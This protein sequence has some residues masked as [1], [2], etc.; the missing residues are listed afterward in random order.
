MAHQAEQRD[1]CQTRSGLRGLHQLTSGFGLWPDFWKKPHSS[2][3]QPQLIYCGTIQR[4]CTF[5][6]CVCESVQVFPKIMHRYEYCCRTTGHESRHKQWSK[7][8]GTHG[9]PKRAF[10]AVCLFS[11]EYLSNHND[12]TESWVTNDTDFGLILFAKLC[13]QKWKKHIHSHTR[14]LLSVFVLFYF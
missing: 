7:V 9:K 3:K 2:W 5:H 14:I 1:E 13:D 10:T 6:Q 11:G 4:P 12:K 8:S